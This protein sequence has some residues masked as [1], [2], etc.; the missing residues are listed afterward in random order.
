[1]EGE[2]VTCSIGHV[3]FGEDGAEAMGN[4]VA[5]VGGRPDLPLALVQQPLFLASGH[6][7]WQSVPHLSHAEALRG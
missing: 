4:Q 5:V 2:S 7:P 6:R 3:A 1:M